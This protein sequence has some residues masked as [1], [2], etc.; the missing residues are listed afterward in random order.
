[1]PFAYVL[2]NVVL[3]IKIKRGKQ[4]KNVAF[5]KLLFVFIDYYY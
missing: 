4:N 2:E 5:T 3:G 1:M